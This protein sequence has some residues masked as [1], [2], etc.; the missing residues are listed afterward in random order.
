MRPSIGM[1]LLATFA[2]AVIAACSYDAGPTAGQV[3]VETCETIRANGPKVPTTVPTGANTDDAKVLTVI[4]YILDNR[5][6]Y[7]KELVA[8]AAA[9]LDLY[10]ASR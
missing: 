8:S 3:A 2:V 1:S 10:R 5:A 4:H 6:C 7:P 9:T